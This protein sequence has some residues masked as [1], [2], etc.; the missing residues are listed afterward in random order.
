MNVNLGMYR[1]E[2][3]SLPDVSESDGP[4]AVINVYSACIGWINVDRI[5]Y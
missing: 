1:I 2:V 3:S 5:V 4:C